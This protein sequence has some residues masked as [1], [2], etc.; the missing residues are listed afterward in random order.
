MYTNHFIQ[1]VIEKILNT[2]N[3]NFQ[4]E[5]ILFFDILSNSVLIQGKAKSKNK[6]IRIIRFLWNS[7]V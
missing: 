7:F 5:N 4:L 2:F 3:R 1:I 6:N